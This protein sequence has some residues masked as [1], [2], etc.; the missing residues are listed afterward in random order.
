MTFR[1]FNNIPQE[2]DGIQFDS[3]KEAHRWGVLRLLEKQGLIRDLRR[4]VSIP[5]EGRDGPIRFQPSNRTAVYKADFVYFDVPKG[6]EVIE[7]RK[8]FQTPEF[9]LKR[10]VLAAQGV[11]IILT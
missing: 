7:D 10:A 3:T 1:K 9:K 5:L 8:G 4:Q 2:V 6:V 11:E